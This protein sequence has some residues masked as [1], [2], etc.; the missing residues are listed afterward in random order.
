V[1]VHAWT[2]YSASARSPPLA[3]PSGS[4]DDVE[5]NL[6]EAVSTGVVRVGLISGLGWS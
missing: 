2:N 1:G 5:A 6:P 3:D 4:R